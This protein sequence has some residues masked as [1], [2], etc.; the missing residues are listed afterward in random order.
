MVEG[1]LQENSYSTIKL[2]WMLNLSALL[3]KEIYCSDYLMLKDNI[4]ITVSDTP[5]ESLVKAVAAKAAQ[6]TL[7]CLE[8]KWFSVRTEGLRTVVDSS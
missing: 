1:I 7:L 6:I 5:T 4:K 8:H 3:Q 2:I